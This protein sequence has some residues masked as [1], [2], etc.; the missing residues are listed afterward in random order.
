MELESL[1]DKKQKIQ[2]LL[3][4][5]DEKLAT[6]E[7]SESIYKELKEKYS[8]EMETLSKQITETELRIE[9]GVREVKVREIKEVKEVVEEEVERPVVKKVRAPPTKPSPSW[10]IPPL[11]TVVIII[12]GLAIFFGLLAAVLS[13]QIPVTDGGR[14]CFAATQVAIEKLGETPFSYLYKIGWFLYYKIFA[15]PIYSSVSIPPISEPSLGIS[16]P[17]LRETKELAS[18]PGCR[19][20]NK[21][22][23]FLWVPIIILFL[24]GFRAGK[25][26]DGAGIGLVAGVIFA[27]LY[28]VAIAVT[29]LVTSISATGSDI[30]AP[31]Q[32]PQQYLEDVRVALYPD[33]PSAFFIS[34]VYAVIF[35]SLGGLLRGAIR[36]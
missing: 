14:G 8:K 36:R 18:L 26:A 21:A 11:T 3:D 34:F 24:G 25:R 4:R 7:I 12:I 35:G 20:I 19:E 9:V 31:I 13:P 6:G 32:V 33:L 28:A 15:I 17:G 23:M 30:Y 22:S 5:L 2:K 1:R 10:L 16:Y 27:I 29:A